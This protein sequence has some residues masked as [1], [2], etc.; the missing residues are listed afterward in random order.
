MSGS[1]FDGVAVALA[2]G[3]L[4]DIGG[5]QPT[6]ST[7][8]DLVLVAIAVA[9]V[10]WFAALIPPMKIAAAV[11]IAGL[12]TTTP[13]GAAVG[14]A[15]AG[16][17]W[18]LARRR[19]PILSTG[20]AGAAGVGLAL[21]LAAR[22]E[23]GVV[24]GASTVVGVVI[25]VALVL[26]A[27]PTRPRWAQRTVVASV[28]GGLAIG[29]IGTAALAWSGAGAADDLRDGERLTRQ[30]L[31]ELADGETDDALTSFTAA[32]AAFG[33]ANDR[34]GG[35]LGLPAALVPGVSQHR[36]AAVEI[37]GRAAD[38]AE[39]I[40]SELAR[41][42]LDDLTLDDGQLDVVA[43]AEL[44][45]PL[46]AIES[47]LVE[48][49]ETVDDVDS[50]WLVEPVA[51]RLED[52]RLEVDEQLVRSGDFVRAIRQVPAMLGAEG[53]RVYF[54]ALTT[55]AEA[56]GLGGFMGNWAEIT[57]DDGRIELS[58]LG[59]SDDLDD[60]A[61]AGE[62]SLTGPEEW[63]DRYGD[64]GFTTD[65]P[66]GV[67]FD[68]WK[69][70]TSS[71]TMSS[72]GQ[73][74]AELYPQSGGRT[75]DGVVAMD[76][77][78]ISALLEFTGPI[79][80]PDDGGTIT[81]E[82]APRFLLNDQYEETDKD[83]R[84]GVLDVVANEVF[85]TLIDGGLPDPADLV[86]SLGPLVEEGRIV[87]WVSRPR[88]QEIFEQ[89]GLAGT[90][91]APDHGDALAVTFDNVIGNKI[92][93]FLRSSAHYDVT[94]G[95]PSDPS[96]TPGDR[97]AG[98]TATLTLELENEAPALDEPNYVI[99]NAMGFDDGVNRT[100]VTIYSRLPVSGIRVDGAPVEFETSSESGFLVAEVV[101]VLESRQ[102][103]TVVIEMT[104]S[105][106]LVDGYE[107]ALRTPPS[108]RPLYTTVQVT[109]SDRTVE[110][111]D[112]VRAGRHSMSTTD[113]PA[114]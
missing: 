103:T 81:A 55:P 112:V 58:D 92:D 85:E 62:R 43:I 4:A 35:P 68:P 39:L 3:V 79:E 98:A 18:V 67:T 70:I 31:D 1:T 41:V 77:F 71:P 51:E 88:E 100:L 83:E 106:D 5:P 56:R 60:A 97:V 107:L 114:D 61:P 16:G 74:I 15:G 59:R 91:V 32:A 21:N 46:T 86:D 2:A 76:V 47:R 53:P 54:V 19:S 50:P 6:G 9:G 12:A 109:S 84:I 90:L 99:G 25:A 10:S 40:A 63:L 44:E 29:A 73:V 37:S 89:V 11:L 57:I 8:I 49:S 69:R 24:L 28:S 75:V 22:S 14:A 113:P 33:E 82:S 101:V 80:L 30:G 94:I 45:E 17:I 105:L 64:R 34:V 95:P 110:T 48:L 42:D 13:I 102:T 26:V 93:F 108:A 27:F 7:T 65:P 78:A 111:W 52:L 20:A 23:L 72:T 66:G 38:A 96:E 104:G 87:G 36:R